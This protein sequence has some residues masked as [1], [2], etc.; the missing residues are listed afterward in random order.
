M[1]LRPGRNPLVVQFWLWGLDA[2]SGDLRSFAQAK[3][4]CQRGSS[5]YQMGAWA[6]HSMGLVLEGKQ[7]LYYDRPAGTFYRC[8]SPPTFAGQVS[9]QPIHRTEGLLAVHG[10]I[11]EYE[12]WISSIHGPFYREK[13]LSGKLPARVR[14]EVQAWKHWMKNDLLDATPSALLLEPSG[15][16]LR[17]RH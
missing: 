12:N 16:V 13:L 4:P 15:S 10:I 5:I 1:P 9:G 11:V 7:Q 14:R 8:D 17:V 6:V 2:V 3:Q